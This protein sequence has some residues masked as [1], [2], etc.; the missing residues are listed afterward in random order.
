MASGIED[1]GLK[2]ASYSWLIVL[3]RWEMGAA[4]RGRL[5]RARWPARTEGD[6]RY[7]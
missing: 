5:D 1:S 7:L 2:I 4:E 6:R 3:T